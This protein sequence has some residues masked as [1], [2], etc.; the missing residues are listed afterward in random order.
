LGLALIKWSRFDWAVEKAA[1]LGAASLTP[2]YTQRTKFSDIG[3]NKLS[4]WHRLA[5]E[6]RKQCGRPLPMIIEEPQKLE[7]FLELAQEG[8]KI[9]FDSSG[10]PFP[11]DLSQALS[12]Q[13]TLVIGPEGGFTPLELSS[14]LNLGFTK[15]SLGPMALKSETAALAALAVLASLAW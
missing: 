10:A 8:P 1:E 15:V 7:Q 11:Q 6:A 2:L 13:A 12:Q 14:A 9:I 3:D 4:R 5:Q